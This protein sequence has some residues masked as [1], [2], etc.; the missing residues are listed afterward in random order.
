[1]V[2]EVVEKVR[3]RYPNEGYGRAEIYHVVCKILEEKEY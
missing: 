1:M 2:K 3:H